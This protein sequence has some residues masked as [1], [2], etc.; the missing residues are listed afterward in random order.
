M[1]LYGTRYFEKNTKQLGYPFCRRDRD[2][3]L[4]LYWKRRCFVSILIGTP[5]EK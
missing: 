4:K 3:K 1:A 5:C 2:Y